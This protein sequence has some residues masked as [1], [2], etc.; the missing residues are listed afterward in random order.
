MQKKKQQKKQTTTVETSVQD[1]QVFMQLFSYPFLAITLLAVAILI[2]HFAKGA[3]LLGLILKYH[4]SV[5]PTSNKNHSPIGLGIRFL[6][7]SF[8]L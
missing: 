7:A 5:L 3:V 2:A 1:C 8:K 4:S 6:S